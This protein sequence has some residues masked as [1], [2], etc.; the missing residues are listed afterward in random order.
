M[1]WVAHI[2]VTRLPLLVFGYGIATPGPKVTAREATTFPYILK[3]ILKQKGIIGVTIARG[4]LGRE[5][6]TIA[7]LAKLF[8]PHGLMQRL[9]NG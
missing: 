6:I 3:E 9:A 1:R 7:R 5:G 4:S 2:G 8:E